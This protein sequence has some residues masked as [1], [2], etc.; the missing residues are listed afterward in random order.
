[1]LGVCKVHIVGEQFG[2]SVFILRC[3]FVVDLERSLV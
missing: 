2:V 1:M 3:L